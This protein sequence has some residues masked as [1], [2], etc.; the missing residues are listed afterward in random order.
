MIWDTYTDQ[1][2]ITGNTVYHKV[3]KLIDA[4]AKLKLKL[5]YKVGEQFKL[6]PH[7]TNMI[8]AMMQLIQQ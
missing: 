5:D 7:Q 1:I 8:R 2:A 4:R 6:R 3:A